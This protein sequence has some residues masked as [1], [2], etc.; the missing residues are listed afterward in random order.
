MS[1]LNGVTW[2]EVQAG[3]TTLTQIFN[4]VDIKVFLERL[5]HDCCKKDFRRIY[6]E[7]N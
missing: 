3:R 4:V 2:I 1:L 6:V 5:D 7:C